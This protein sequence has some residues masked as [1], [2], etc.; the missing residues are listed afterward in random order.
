MAILDKSL[1]LA[2]GQSNVRAANAGYL[3]TN[4]IDLGPVKGTKILQERGV[5]QVRI[6]TAYATGD[7]LEFQ[8][9]CADNDAL[10]TNAIV[11][12]SSG[13]ILTA[14]LTANKILWET[15][16]PMDI[17]KRYLGVKIVAVAAAAFTA[18]THDINI[19]VGTQ[20]GP[21]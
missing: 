13:T 1:Q 17:P 21:Y 16:V 12:K 10:S 18:G 5:L 6:G 7:S 3:S 19:A 4:V 20:V 9:V 8:L 14:A 11:L 2:S 15:E